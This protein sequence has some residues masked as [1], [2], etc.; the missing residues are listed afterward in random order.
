M[1]D[2]AILRID[3]LV[4]DGVLAG[5]IRP[6][7]RLIE[8][9]LGGIFGVSRTRIREALIRLKARGI[10]RVEPRRGWFVVEPSI[11]EAHQAFAARRAIEVGLLHC[12][13]ALDVASIRRLGV[14]IGEEREAIA[15]GDVGRRSFLLGDFHV[16]L[17]GILGNRLIA[18][19]VRDL[20]ARTLLISM[21]YQ[22]SHDACAS[23]TDHERILAALVDRDI[24]GAAR[25]MA[26]H[27]GSVETALRLPPAPDPL[28]SLREVLR[29]QSGRRPPEFPPTDNAT[30]EIR[31]ES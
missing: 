10:V 9:Q 18:D 11:D 29:P 4:V 26:S 27:I 5:R 19:I 16:C 22:S 2:S 25:L 24:A 15:H 8:Q 30:K 14:H 21:L 7:T 13:A 6:G 20:T 28:A 1:A 31:H 23:C 12:A 17:A 3:E